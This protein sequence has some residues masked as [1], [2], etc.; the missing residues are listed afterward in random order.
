MRNFAGCR[1]EI[2]RKAHEYVSKS[3]AGST[4][5]S[6]PDWCF[7][8]AKQDIEQNMRSERIVVVAQRDQDQPD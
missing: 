6:N 3:A 2:D 7:P 5:S 4:C 8:F 1:S